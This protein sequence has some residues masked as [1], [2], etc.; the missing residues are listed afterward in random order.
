MEFTAGLSLWRECYVIELPDN[1]SGYGVIN[2]MRVGR[3]TELTSVVAGS[4]LAPVL[5]QSPHC[6]VL[7]GR[8]MA[9]H[10]SGERY[11]PWSSTGPI[12]VAEIN[13]ACGYM[14]S[15]LHE[16]ARRNRLTLQKVVLHPNA[17][18]ST[19]DVPAP[20][21]KHQTLDFY[22]VERFFAWKT[23]GE[24]WV[25][26]LGGLQ[27]MVQFLQQALNSRLSVSARGTSQSAFAPH[28]MDATAGVVGGFGVKHGSVSEETWGKA[29]RCVLANLDWCLAAQTA[30][31][32]AQAEP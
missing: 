29:I 24:A 21:K 5:L 30:L 31:E 16:L 18:E 19:I 10:T 22:I 4:T 25:A 8:T 26:Y 2:G 23:F 20:G 1:T 14:A 13:G 3:F 17:H 9:R 27:E 32:A 15:A 6:G 28:A 11:F 7:H 12:T